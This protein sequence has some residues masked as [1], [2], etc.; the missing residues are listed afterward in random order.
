[1][2]NENATATI[3]VEY[4]DGETVTFQILGKV[5]S[6]ASFVCWQEAASTDVTYSPAA[7]IR[8]VVHE[9]SGR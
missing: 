2:I 6:Y 5:W 3:T 8:R 9:G 4:V 1:M 7:N